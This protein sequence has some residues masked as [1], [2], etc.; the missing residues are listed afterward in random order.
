MSNSKEP[1]SQT[2][3]KEIEETIDEDTEE[4]E[5]IRVAYAIKNGL[6]LGIVS[7]LTLILIAIIV[8]YALGTNV[9][10]VFFEDLVFLI[11]ASF[12]LFSGFVIW[13]GPS[14]QW[15]YIKKSVSKQNTEPISTAD[16]LTMGL[17]R[18]ITA[19]LLI[20]IISL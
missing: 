7:Y 11:A 14:P 5:K 8:N 13:F 18:S 20:I 4:D 3:P 17:S 15:A 10:L 6:F 9:L 19:I 16:S 12:F 2:L 1:L